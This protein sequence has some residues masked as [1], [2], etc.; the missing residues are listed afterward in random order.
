MSK[1]SQENSSGLTASPKHFLGGIS[2]T[3]VRVLGI[4]ILAMDF[5]WLKSCQQAANGQ[6]WKH[7]GNMVRTK[8]VVFRNLYLNVCSNIKYKQIHKINEA[9]NLKENWE[10]GLWG[11]EGGW[12]KEREGRNGVIRI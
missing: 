3:L 7:M 2:K 11:W 4:A 9:T 6:P 8:Q 10:K 5:V 1:Y 12:R